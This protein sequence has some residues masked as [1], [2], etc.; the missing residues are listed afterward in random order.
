MTVDNVRTAYVN[1]CFD[2]KSIVTA[3]LGHNLTI[4]GRA[5]Y[6]GQDADVLG[7]RLMAFN[8]LLHTVT[9]KLMYLV[10]G[11]FD[12]FPDDEFLDVL[13]EKAQH[14]NC[15]LDLV[16]AFRWSLPEPPTGVQPISSLSA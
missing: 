7:S 3:R 10:D 11:N 12:A 4:A 5:C 13:F 14:N 8:E 16:D 15:V 6:P 9:A 2:S 1:L